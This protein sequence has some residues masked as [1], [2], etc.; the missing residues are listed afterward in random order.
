MHRVVFSTV[1]QV[2][3]TPPFHT[4]GCQSMAKEFSGLHLV[5]LEFFL[6]DDL[7]LEDA[8]LD[9]FVRQDDSTIEVELI[10]HKHV[11]TDHCHVLEA[12]PLAN[13]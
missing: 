1:L 12:G 7:W 3:M 11:L 6:H 4:A 9:L 5:Q 8:G 2:Q 13:R 10:L